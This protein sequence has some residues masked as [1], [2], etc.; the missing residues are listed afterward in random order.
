M[1]DAESEIGANSQSVAEVGMNEVGIDGEGG[2]DEVGVSGEVVGGIDV[3]VGR[4]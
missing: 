4:E 2:A 3:V 1:D